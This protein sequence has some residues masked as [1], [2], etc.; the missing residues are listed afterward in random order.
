MS[1]EPQ[2][3]GTVAWRRDRDE[4]NASAE[5]PRRGVGADGRCPRDE[6]EPPQRGFE[7]E[8]VE[9][10][11]QQVPTTSAPPVLAL[12]LIGFLAGLHVV[13]LASLAIGVSLTGWLVAPA[14]AIAALFA[15]A[16][17]PP[18]QGVRITLRAIALVVA[19]TAAA[20]A[21][22][23]CFYDVSWD[24]QAYHQPAVLALAQG[25]NPLHDG[26]LSTDTRPDNLWINHYP[27]AIWIAQAILLRATGSLEA[28]KGLQLV[29][30][31][32]AAL[33]VV[34]LLR[35]RGLGRGASL[36]AAFALVANPVALAQLY[37][38]YVDGLCASL[39]LAMLA[40][41]WWWTRR[42]RPVTMLAIAACLSLLI[43]TKF[44]GLVYSGLLAAGA[45][46]FV[47]HRRRAQARPF[48]LA[49]AVALAV[50]T[51]GLGFDPYV[52]NLVRKGHPFY[53]VAG[54]GAVDFISIQLT[55]AVHAQSRPSRLLLG[56]FSR[57]DNQNRAPQLKWPLSIDRAELTALSYADTR[58]G[59]FGP[60]FGAA[61]LL[62]IAIAL[63]MRAP[64]A[65]WGLG[66]LLLATAF[67][68]PALWWAR[69]VPQLWWL[70]AG[71]ATLAIARLSGPWGLRLATGALAALIAIDTA[72][73]G[74]SAA[75][76][77]TDATR[78]VAAE[79]DSLATL[80]G[81]LLVR[82]NSFEAD[83][84]RLQA[85]GIAF[86]TSTST[87]LPC[88][89]PRRLFGSLAEIC[90]APALADAARVERAR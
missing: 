90:P 75:A 13:G 44:T 34:A 68:N 51:L 2:R 11:R 71:V 3:Q 59:G 43:N 72:V 58:I 50:G 70:P 80:P 40:L 27:K 87:R 12:A 7:V 22:G 19:I 82:W 57:A 54:A 30:L 63:A 42:P 16:G 53:P 39:M 38:F 89:A 18:R 88:R 41:V 73:V 23:A 32:A 55:P 62:A 67:A 65:A 81:P 66:G 35:A 1:T 46:I 10:G 83:A 60:L 15:A 61:L 49:L 52:T 20:L 37:S 86:R 48:A 76:G 69:Y 6:T 84:D 77:Q 78:A 8:D 45:A 25:W 26:P 24:G 21:L 74:A 31:V 85:R 17:A 36:L 33:L 28:T 47:W 56:L 79:L 14:L 9:R 29:P 4:T 5:P 64:R